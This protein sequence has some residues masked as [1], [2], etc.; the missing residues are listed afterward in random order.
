MIT[1]LSV[2]SILALTKHTALLVYKAQSEELDNKR[3]VSDVDKHVF[4]GSAEDPGRVVPD[5]V[6]SKGIESVVEEISST[7]E[8]IEAIYRCSADSVA[9][10]FARVGSELLPLIIQITNHEVRRRRDFAPDSTTE[11]GAPPEAREI[12]LKIPPR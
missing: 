7:C 6:N 9:A 2:E 1:R 5:L 3:K 12:V 8:V 10:S 11:I 4:G